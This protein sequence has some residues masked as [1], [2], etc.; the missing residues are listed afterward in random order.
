MNRD[1]VGPRE[2]FAT[3]LGRALLEQER[4]AVAEALECVFGE[5]CLQVGAWGPPGLFLDLAR[6]QRRALLSAAG[7]AA[8]QVRAY[9]ASLAIQ[10]DSIDA[11]LLPHTL[12]L[13]SD[14]HEVLREAQRVLRPEGC[15]VVLGFEPLGSWAMRGRFTRGG[16]PPGTA[17][18]LSE[19]RLA[20]WLKLLGLDVDPASRF[21]FTLPFAR[22]QSGRM[23]RWA[24]GAG[25]ALGSRLSGAYVLRARKRVHAVTPIRLKY[26]ARPAVIGGLAEP[27][28]RVGT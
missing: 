8:G 14:P 2:W 5:Q 17:R 10:S 27:T 11:L 1:P 20:D 18:L 4:D 16:F 3:P 12:E 21:L 7:D 9:P 6:T 28:T 23:R 13:E 26:R 15:L 22:A 19:R 25:K 24:D